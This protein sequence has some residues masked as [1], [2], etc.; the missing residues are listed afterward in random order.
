M[1]SSLMQS[2]LLFSLYWVMFLLGAVVARVF[3]RAWKKERLDPRR[4]GT[5]FV[6]ATAVLYLLLFSW[7]MIF[8]PSA[9]RGPE[10]PWAAAINVY[11]TSIGSWAMFMFIIKRIYGGP[12]VERERLL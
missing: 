4:T 6:Y 10:F 3:N 8:S 2:L 7:L 1:L 11:L 12:K 5:Q 9:Q